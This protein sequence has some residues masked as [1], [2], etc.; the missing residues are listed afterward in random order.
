VDKVGKILAQVMPK[1]SGT[2]RPTNVEHG[3]LS[4][5]NMAGGDTKHSSPRPKAIPQ[6][7]TPQASVVSKG[8]MTTQPDSNESGR[9]VQPFSDRVEKPNPVR[10]RRLGASTDLT[11]VK[12]IISKVLAYR[13]LD[14]KVER[15]EFILHWSSIVGERLA[16]VTKPECIRNRALIV[17]VVHPVWAQELVMMKPI[18]LQSLARYLKPGDIVS[19]I[20]CRAGDA[21]EIRR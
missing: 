6:A 11:K 20:V 10:R 2:T 3:R 9:A 18:I 7:S 19:D 12:G 8:A 4:S 15:Y 21:A 17:Q 16:E 14:K 5:R 1:E 13:G